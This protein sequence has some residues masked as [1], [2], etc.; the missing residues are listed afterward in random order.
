MLIRRGQWIKDVLLIRRG[1]W[2]KDVL[3]IEK[4]TMDKGCLAHKNNQETRV[5]A[6]K[7][8]GRG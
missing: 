7:W 8:R 1:Q 3:L 5:K 6:G 4:R 2:I